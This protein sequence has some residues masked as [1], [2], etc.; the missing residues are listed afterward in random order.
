MIHTSLIHPFLLFVPILL[1][2]TSLM[3][4]VAFLLIRVPLISSLALV[5][6]L[7][8]VWLRASIVTFLRLL[9]LYYSPRS[10]HLTSRLR[11]SPRLFFLSTGSPPPFFRGVLLTSAFCHPPRY[12]HL[13]RFGRVC[14]VLLLPREH[15]KLTA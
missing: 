10:F 9:V 15:T 5:L 1:E 13:L 3:H 2:S 12:S 11:L 8:M 7:R 4:I 6:M 14:Y